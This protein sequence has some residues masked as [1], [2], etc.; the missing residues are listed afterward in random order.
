M[1]SWMGKHPHWL[2]A[3]V[4][5]LMFFFSWSGIAQEIREIDAVDEKEA[6]AAEE[7]IPSFE[8]IAPLN[9]ETIA[10]KFVFII[11]PER[12]WSDAFATV[13]LSSDTGKYESR[14]DGAEHWMHAL[15]STALPD[16]AYALT[17]SFCASG[18]CEEKQLTIVIDNSVAP[19]DP[20]SGNTGGGEP[21]KPIEPIDP[22]DP[23]KPVDPIM[24]VESILVIPS[25]HAGAFYISDQ[26][27]LSF[28]FKSSGDT[29]K[30]AKGVYDAQLEFF[31]GRI[32][33]IRVTRAKLDHDG[34][35]AAWDDNPITQPFQI[36]NQLFDPV[37]SYALRFEYGA[38]NQQIQFSPWPEY[39]LVWCRSWNRDAG[40][41]TR[42]EVLDEEAANP[43]ITTS[44]DEMVVVFAKRTPIPSTEE[45]WHSIIPSNLP[46]KFIFEETSTH[47]ITPTTHTGIEL[48][49]GEYD[50]NAYF[51]SL[52]IQFI[53]LRAMQVDRNEVVLQFPFVQRSPDGVVT[54]SL[55]EAFSF[56]SGFFAIS[57]EYANGSMWSCP[58]WNVSANECL[59][60]WKRTY[61]TRVQKGTMFLRFFPEG[62]DANVEPEPPVAL[63]DPAGL[64]D[65]T[66]LL[67]SIAKLKELSVNSTLFKGENALRDFTIL[68]EL[69]SDMEIALE[70]DPAKLIPPTT[71]PRTPAADSIPVDVIPA[72]VIPEAQTIPAASEAIDM[73]GDEPDA[74]I[75]LS[76]QSE[77]GVADPL[78]TTE[79]DSIPL[80]IPSAEEEESP[81]F[82]PPADVA[83]VQVLDE[84]FSSAWEKDKP[85]RAVDTEDLTSCDGVVLRNAFTQQRVEPEG[86]RLFSL[87]DLR[88]KVK[89]TL[90]LSNETF[91]EQSRTVHIRLFSR[92]PAAVAER[93]TIIPSTDYVG[94]RTKK[95]VE[96]APDST[97]D[98]NAIPVF[99]ERLANYRM[100]LID[101]NAREIGVYDWKDYWDANIAPITLVHAN[102]Q[103]MIIDTLVRVRLDP[104]STRV[105]DPTY[106]LSGYPN[107]SAGWDGNNSGDVLGNTHDSNDGVR[108]L[109]LDNNASAND[110]VITA[111]QVDY[112][113]KI[114]VGAVYIIK[115]FNKYNG[116]FGL[117]DTNNYDVAFFGAN[118]Y[119]QLG[120]TTI[121]NIGS[122]PGVQF[123]DTDGNGY[124]N[125]LIITAVDAD[126]NNKANVGAVYYI[127]DV[128]KLKGSFSLASMDKVSVRWNGS[129]AA[130]YIGYTIS[131]GP[132]VLV[133]NLDANVAAN[134]LIIG[135]ALANTNQTDSGT[136]YV[137]KD[138]NTIGGPLDINRVRDLNHI[139]NFSVRFDANHIASE[140]LTTTGASGDGI[141]VINSDGN[142]VANDLII[143]TTVGDANSKTDAGKVYYIKDVNTLSGEK[144]FGQ[145]GSFTAMWHG[146][147]SWLLGNTVTNQGSAPGLKIVDLN[148]DGYFNDMLVLASFGDFNGKSDNG[149]LFLITDFN[150]ISGVIDLNNNRTTDYLVKWYSGVASDRLGSKTGNSQWIGG[151]FADSMQL[152]NLDGNKGANDL[153]IMSQIADFNGKTD[154]GTI[155]L[156]KDINTI[157]GN[158]D[159][160]IPSN[161]SILWHGV[162]NDN[163]GF[164]RNQDQSVQVVNIDGNQYA[165]DLLITTIN[166]D[167]NGKSNTG[168]VVLITD[169][170]AKSGLHYIDNFNH[171]TARWSGAASEFLGDT[172]GSRQGVQLVNIDN[173]A[174]ANDLIIT[175]PNAD[176]NGYTDNGVIYLI[177]DINRAYTAGP[178]SRSFDLNSPAPGMFAA[179]WFLDG[180]RQFLG[181]TSRSGFGVIVADT[182]NNGYANDLIITASKADTTVLGGGE[183]YYV[184]DIDKVDGNRLLSQD[185]SF[186][187]EFHGDTNFDGLGDT[188]SSGSGVIL[189]DADGNGYANDLIITAYNKDI[190]VLGQADKNL[191]FANGGIFL[192][193]D[194]VNGSPASGILA[195]N[196]NTP[197]IDTNVYGVNETI[198]VNATVFCRGAAC[199][200]VDTNLQY[201]VGNACQSNRFVDMN[202]VAGSP[203]YILS[204]TPTQSQASMLTNGSYD[205]NWTITGASDY[206]YELRLTSFGTTSIRSYSDGMDRTIVL[207]PAN[208]FDLGR[209]GSYYSTYTGS[210]NTD[211]LS[212][213]NLSTQNV[214]YRN[215]D[216]GVY[217]ND[218]IVTSAYS[219]INGKTNAGTIHVFMNVDINKGD[220]DVNNTNNFSLRINGTVNNDLVG[221]THP[222]TYRAPHEHGIQVMDING[223]GLANDLLITVPNADANGKS[224]SGAIYLI[225][226]FHT[227]T[228]LLD[229]NHTANFD[230]IITGNRPNDTI[231]GSRNSG[232]GAQIVNLD[233][234]LVANDLIIVAPAADQNGKTDNGAIYIIN[235]INAKSGRLDLNIPANYDTV[236]SGGINSD[237]LGYTESTSSGVRLYNTDGNSWANDLFIVSALAD[238]NGK[239]NPGAVYFIQDVNVKKGQIDFNNPANF[240]VRWNGGVANDQVTN[241]A[242]VGTCTRSGDD[243][244]G[245]GVFDLDGE[246]YPNDLLIGGYA[247]DLNRTDVGAVYLIMDVNT[248]SL[249][250]RD[251]NNTNNY[252]AVWNGGGASHVI[253]MNCTSSLSFNQDGFRVMNIDNGAQANDL[254]IVASS[255]GLKRTSS[256]VIYVIQNIDTNTGRKDLNNTNNFRFSIHGSRLTDQLGDTNA[257]G[258]AVQLVNWDGGAFAND[259]IINVPYA[260]FNALSNN[261]MIYYLKN[262]N[263][264]TGE[265]D[266]NNSANYTTRWYGG[267]TLDA[268]GDSNLSSGNSVLIADLDGNGSAND[269]LIVSSLADY[270]K[271]VDNGAIYMILDA[272]TRVADQ[273]LGLPANVT[274]TWAGAIDK[275]YLGA[276]LRNAGVTIANLDNNAQANDLIITA[277]T[278][279]VN[280]KN[281]SGGVYIIQDANAVRGSKTLANKDSYTKRYSGARAFDWLSN[282]FSSYKGISTVDLDN[283]SYSN[284][285]IFSIP[286]ADGNNKIDNGA[287]AI[288]QNALTVPGPAPDDYSFVLMLPSNSCQDGLGNQEGVDG[289]CH[290]AWFEA[291]DVIGLA[292]E[293]QVNADGQSDGTPFL[294]YDNQSSTASDLNILLDLNQALPV[295][296]VLKVSKIFA[297][298]AG[299]CTGNTDNNCLLVT[300]TATSAGR[301]LYSAGTQDLNLYVWGDFNGASTGRVDRNV[302]SNSISP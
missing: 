266:L 287:V 215:L 25:N 6:V 52:P 247:V 286:F 249:G 138:I 177:R 81:I 47:I 261:G 243:K 24:N 1:H 239:S 125:D 284:D 146:G 233:G 135:A 98:A 299:T 185:S 301:A 91:V 198:V 248:L 140:N 210:L 64:S 32:A 5:V 113:G 43:V 9:K 180:N 18:I 174:W 71:K 16:G 219:D 271:F 79:V 246:G 86:R 291:T 278:A 275:D 61:E 78:T 208:A 70:C 255:V 10:G 69:F 175:S 295:S 195:Y 63:P 257:N 238:V 252:T 204:G 160:N 224:G 179:R 112:N 240:T 262:V 94:L 56:S 119:D 39:A 250:P 145:T 164:N 107:F 111:P 182:D 221:D 300:T 33:H 90:T 2:L 235:D 254:M 167:V 173:N 139:N 222:A 74:N 297:G 53:H 88:S 96:P 171:I 181:D 31:E 132:G 205:V 156:V 270:N 172:N 95:I 137:I 116:L 272:N 288:V 131:G 265:V 44:E 80:M 109:N 34:V 236:F 268:A 165:N 289:P 152:I 136:V 228:G 190:N 130:D 282:P 216:N 298:W 14:F 260:D 128:D 229:L 290:R 37:E 87:G 7:V 217:A 77:E 193:K 8:V 212:Y 189:L 124:A 203:L 114:N 28:V 151:R 20:P 85:A 89:Q 12:E 226:N 83:P 55:D 227:R 50:V 143:Q 75:V 245:F 48:R 274:A 194:I 51:D 40:T 46:S 251:F 163:L 150:T 144:K 178:T 166:A 41:C 155:Y 191:V 115:D 183:I 196:F 38:E 117:A 237:Q 76:F 35:I 202:A 269:L 26:T 154:N 187:S 84:R 292:D 256:G 197:R 101:A 201:C 93:Q 42:A 206:N 200:N 142:V 276:G 108:V 283:N 211:A 23:V 27:D 57:R 59:G 199:G 230:L 21:V 126:V 100:Q 186:F 253:T 105:I 19:I 280:L 118:H 54:L 45:R 267:V 161:Y 103:G 133:A 169:I 15:D 285:L 213:A 242:N 241:T 184:R 102:E 244:N 192:I 273:N 104:I 17:L 120:K 264:L 162:A 29:L 4:I 209:R 218:L 234:N 281:Q 30:I 97:E 68:G 141:M 147:G 220:L 207:E 134:D 72:D 157:S 159:L 176:A 11:K 22:V 58:V 259:F 214:V 3:G 36:N 302:D 231:G 67:Q 223:D 153:I 123:F 225:E 148:G 258:G 129:G 168:S 13:Q 99:V 60:S 293:N 65:E 92:H 149:V 122:G 170:N 73:P 158:R 82:T 106:E 296:L 279:S 263:N 121:S 110:L 232:N 66:I 294:Q 277:P 49:A 62:V 188:N 127:K